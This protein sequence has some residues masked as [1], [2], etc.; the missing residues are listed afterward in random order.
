MSNKTQKFGALIEGFNSF[1]DSKKA[2]EAQGD[3][4]TSV[5]AVSTDPEVKKILPAVGSNVDNAS[6][7]GVPVGE[8]V[9]GQKDPVTTGKQMDEQS[10]DS[11]I[12]KVAS[13]DELAVMANRVMTKIASINAEYAKGSNATAAVTKTASAQPEI[14][15]TSDQINLIAQKTAQLQKDMEVGQQ[16]GNMLFNNTGI[17]ASVRKTASELEEAGLNRQDV[18]IILK[19][20]EELYPAFVEKVAEELVLDA[21]CEN[22]AHE[23]KQAGYNEAQVVEFFKKA[24]EYDAIQTVQAHQKSAAEAELVNVCEQKV[25]ELKAAGY[26]EAQM[27]Q[28]FFEA[29]RNDAMAVKQANQK[30][31]AEAELVNICEQKVAELKHAGYDDAQIEQ[32]F[33]E[34][35]RNDAAA[36]RKQ[37]EDAAAEKSEIAP[38]IPGKVT[39]VGNPGTENKNT[40]KPEA[41]RPEDA[42]AEPGSKLAYVQQL[43]TAG[44]DDATIHK[45]IVAV[46]GVGSVLKTA[47]ISSETITGVF[48]RIQQKM[49]KVVGR[50]KVAQ[51]KESNK[52]NAQKIANEMAAAASEDPAVAQA[53]AEEAAGAPVAEEPVPVDPAIAG[54]AEGGEDPQAVIEQIVSGLEQLVQSGQITEEEAMAVLSELGLIPAEGAVDPAAAGA[55]VDP[56]AAGAPVA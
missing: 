24:G 3:K 47:G 49:A 15:I 4:E 5:P 26:N 7:Q 29:G 48:D 44:L 31:A 46:E 13:A 17:V 27:E 22:K 45:H 19:R 55:P 10:P 50:I 12:E 53:L 43:K 6:M 21:T 52:G 56:A 34:A 20:A 42:L 25:A 41:P 8:K 23:L 11:K 38:V 51:I 1:L 39:K 18:D 14:T 2:S 30:S 33:F 37:A 36:L 28:Y 16:I 35:G 9:E 32:Y 54:G 40:D